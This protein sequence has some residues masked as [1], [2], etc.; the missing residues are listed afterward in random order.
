[1]RKLMILSLILLFSATAF[2]DGTEWFKGS[3]DEAMDL[4][5]KEGKLILI[6]FTSPG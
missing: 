4:A 6:H 2:A 5:K 1:M 3:F